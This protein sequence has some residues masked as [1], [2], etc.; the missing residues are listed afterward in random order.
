M[1]HSS[2]GGVGWPCGLSRTYVG[3]GPG[4]KTCIS[5]Q[6]ETF[7]F[8]SDVSTPPLVCCGWIK[9]CKDQQDGSI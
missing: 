6:I 7:V 2:G 3:E 1:L 5:Y 8:M 9:F 4:K